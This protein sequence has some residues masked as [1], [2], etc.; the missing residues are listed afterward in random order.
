MRAATMSHCGRYRYSL[1][2]RITDADDT[3][4]SRLAW[5][6]LNPST[7]DAFRDDPT[8]RKVI[9]FTRRAGFDSALVVNLYAWRATDPRELRRNHA[10]AEGLRN[11][12]AVLSAATSSDAVVCAWGAT[13]WAREQAHRVIGWLVEHPVE[14]LCLG[15]SKA[16]APLHPLMLSYAK[17]PLQPFR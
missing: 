15:R 17:H 10:R 4:S 5:L 6:M 16:G 8:I 13:P 14:L 11:R 1:E 7:A 2:R 12:K 9:G 3:R